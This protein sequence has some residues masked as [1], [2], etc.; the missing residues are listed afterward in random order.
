MEDERTPSVLGCAKENGGINKRHT[1]RNKNCALE[2][3][4][5]IT[6]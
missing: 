1:D 4:S 5:F 2:L 3:F 6:N